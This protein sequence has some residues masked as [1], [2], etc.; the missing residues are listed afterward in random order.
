MNIQDLIKAAQVAQEKDTEAKRLEEEAKRLEEAEKMARRLPAEIWGLLHIDPITAQFVDGKRA[1]EAQG[2]VDLL[3]DGDQVNVWVRVA[4]DWRSELQIAFS[5]LGYGF[6][7]I[8]PYRDDPTQAPVF[9]G[10]ALAKAQ[11]SLRAGI[12]S[13]VAKAEEVL[14]DTSS[15]WPRNIYQ[16]ALATLSKYRPEGQAEW[17][18]LTAGHLAAREAAEAQRAEDLRRWQETRD[19][20]TREQE[21]RREKARAWLEDWRA[22]EPSFNAAIEANKAHT[23][24]MQAEADV[25]ASVLRITYGVV[26]VDEED[27]RYLE[28]RTAYAKAHGLWVPDPDIGWFDVYKRGSMETTPTRYAHLVKVERVDT[29]PT[30]GNVYAILHEDFT[31]LT[32]GP[33][34]PQEVIDRWRA[35]LLPLPNSSEP[36]PPEWMTSWDA[37][38]LKEGHSIDSI[39]S[40]VF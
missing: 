2:W 29:R 26:A 7:K 11:E 6:G 38:R 37:D 33:A 39:D 24:S 34:T 30:E 23:D 10:A 9:I 31:R 32:V 21:R 22:W 15:G 14:R 3:G 40:I 8:Y 35:G 36:E 27:E 13:T 1:L 18:A 17:E 4:Y 19:R 12:A 5:G 25:P 16:E 28:T 20:E